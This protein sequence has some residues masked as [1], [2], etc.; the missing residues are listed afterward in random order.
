MRQNLYSFLLLTAF[1]LMLGQLSAQYQWR[2]LGP[3]NVSSITRAL[4]FDQSANLYAGAQGGGLWRSVDLGDSWSKLDSYESAGCNPNITS[5]AIDGST[6]YVA[7]GA[8]Q[9]T[10]PFI[11]S[12]LGGTPGYDYRAEKSGFIG[13][14]DGLPGG[15][16]YVSTDNGVTWQDSNATNSGAFA[17]TLQYQGPF[18]D[19]QKV[20]VSNGRVIIGTH[21]GVFFSDNQLNTVTKSEGSDFLKNNTIF[22]IEVASNNSIYVIAHSFVNP[23]T[24][25]SLFVSRDNGATFTAITDPEIFVSGRVGFVRSELA[26]SPSDNNIL[27]LATTEASGGIGSIFKLNISE[28]K[29]STV[30]VA[31][32]TFEP[33][34]IGGQDAFILSVYPDN[35]DELVVA[36][37]SWYTLTQENGWQLIGQSFIPSLET[38]REAPMYSLAFHP[39]D[40]SI[41]ALGT[42]SNIFVSRDRGETFASRNRGYGTHP[43][44]SVASV[45]SEVI[46]D[47]ESTLYEAVVAGSR[48]QVLVNHLFNT[49]L[50]SK[51]SFGSIASIGYTK[52]EYS[53]INPGGMIR[54]GPDGGLVRSLDFGLTFEP[55]YQIPTSP[56]VPNLVPAN[57]DTIINQTDGSSAAGDLLD[58]PTPAQAIWLLDEYI[59]EDM[60]GKDLNIEEELQ[61][62]LESNVFFC[63][64]KY[65][66]IAKGAFGDVLQA[67]W[68]RLTSE[69]VDGNDEVFTA[70]TISNDGN[71]TLYVATS[72]GNIY[73]ID[74]ANDLSN[75]DAAKN[76]VKMN[77][78]LSS[79]GLSLIGN[80]I[81]SLD[82]DPQN[83]DRL[84]ITYAGYGALSQG[85]STWLWITD[86][87]RDSVPVFGEVRGLP[88]SNPIYTSKWVVD[89]S[90]NESVL[91]IGTETGVKALRNIEDQGFPFIP[92]VYLPNL[93]NPIVD[94]IPELATTPVMDIGVRKYSWVENGDFINI[95]K[96]YTT[97]LA[98]YGQGVWTSSDFAAPRK[99]SGE[100]K[101]GGEI[102]SNFF[103]KLYP[104]PSQ[105]A[106]ILQ[107]NV[108]G[109]ADLRV[110]IMDISGRVYFQENLLVSEGVQKIELPAANLAEGLYMVEVQAKGEGLSE[111]VIHKWA[112]L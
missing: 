91:L 84:I 50:P 100:E 21:E 76:V 49:D 26:V 12:D 44:I 104:N 86:N 39:T 45:K 102:I 95:S 71:H 52:L 109:K 80:W 2:S 96:D 111:T 60:I 90:N 42:S 1:S 101:P 85:I 68:N 18:T 98:S 73:R 64:Q 74:N 28:N 99:S 38:Y 30:G 32:P 46:E 16:V 8:T 40:P 89:P 48:N 87:A 79:S 7:T 43:L 17:S 77:E 103:T 47:G 11:E 56:Q 81:S 15:G 63:S 6:I 59:P 34:G 93:S 61:A 110:R 5:I 92:R 75:F 37:S 70:M 78:S 14:L 72:L 83:P 69:L 29:W 33:L 55:F 106:A 3:D 82:I 62:Q 20:I 67:R 22:D 88:F 108:P 57:S 41:I 23:E 31:G 35:P 107:V 24:T 51:N 58:A 9:F 27:Y 10:P 25:D 54:Q 4:A 19:I 36:G 53:V 94:E 112:N 13:Y 105:G 66:W 97:F 65:V